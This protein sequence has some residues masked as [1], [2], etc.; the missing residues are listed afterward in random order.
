METNTT[1]ASLL[2]LGSLLTR[3]PELY[4]NILITGLM[5]AD[6]GRT[7]REGGQKKGGFSEFLDL[8]PG[9]GEMTK[10]AP[11]CLTWQE[12]GSASST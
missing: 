5:M 6:R 9:I 11:R 10:N 4:N 12:K 1:I 2:L 7:G 3:G 8:D